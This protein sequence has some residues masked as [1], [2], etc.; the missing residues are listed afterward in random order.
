MYLGMSFTEKSMHE[1]A[2]GELEKAATLSTDATIMKAQLGYAYAAAGRRGDAERILTELEAL[3]RERYVSPYDLAVSQFALG[4]KDRTFEYL[5]KAY[6]ERSRRLWGLKVNPIW[7][8][9]RPDPRF[10]NLLQR[11]GLSL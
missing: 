9:L 3:S 4:D 11:I 7:D 1:A 2:I 8:N 6:A 5:E 10:A